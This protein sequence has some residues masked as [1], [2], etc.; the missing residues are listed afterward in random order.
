MAARR[1]AHIGILNA[2]ETLTIKPSAMINTSIGTII[3]AFYEAS[4]SPDKIYIITHLEDFQLFAKAAQQGEA[5][6]HGV[7]ESAVSSSSTLLIAS[8]LVASF[9]QLSSQTAKF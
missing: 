2:L 4:L 3:G 6:T 9:R 1:F 5:K 8:L 7:L